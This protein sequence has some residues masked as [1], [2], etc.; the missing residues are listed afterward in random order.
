MTEVCRYYGIEYID[1]TFESIVNR[2]NI[3]V[4]LPDGVHPSRDAHA[5][6]ARELGGKIR[7]I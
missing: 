7:F 3:A 5:M 1:Q 2:Q 6:I 4:M